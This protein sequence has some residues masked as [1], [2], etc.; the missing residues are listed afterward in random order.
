MM[1]GNFHEKYSFHLSNQYLKNQRKGFDF[2][3][4]TGKS[5]RFYSFVLDTITV[6]RAFYFTLKESNRSNFDFC[7]EFSKYNYCIKRI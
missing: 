4:L 7:L 5:Y 6:F 3:I 1:R 2:S